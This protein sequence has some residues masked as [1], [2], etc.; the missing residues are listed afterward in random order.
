[1]TC[2]LLLTRHASE[3]SRQTDKTKKYTRFR[4]K[5]LFLRGI[6]G[7]IFSSLRGYGGGDEKNKLRL[8]HFLIFL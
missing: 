6:I 5:C 2:Y 8:I 7:Y 3:S 4:Q 1:M